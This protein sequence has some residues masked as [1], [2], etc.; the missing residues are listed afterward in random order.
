MKIPA[1]SDFVAALSRGSEAF[2]TLSDFSVATNADGDI[3]VSRTSL[4]AEAQIEIRGDKYLL[5]LPV[6]PES[7][8]EVMPALD[9]VRRLRGRG[10]LLDYRLLPDEFAYIDSVGHLCSCDLILLGMPDGERLDEAVTCV[11]TQQLLLALDALRSEFVRCGVRHRNLKPSNLVYCPDGRL[12]AVRCHYLA[13]ESDVAAIE[14]E[15]AEVEEFIRSH[16][17]IGDGCGRVA[18][19]DASN[20]FDEIVPLHDMMQLVRSGELFGYLDADGSVVFEPQFTY[21]ESFFENRAVVE[22]G[23]GHMGVI[24]R[25]GRSIVRQE[26][27]MVRMTAD[28]HF[29]VLRDGLAGEYDY[30][31]VEVIPLGAGVKFLDDF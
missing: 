13:E 21:A 31:G 22:N 27:D 7:I 20:G 24:D 28:G 6:R 15:F 16:P 29:R 14:S 8:D 25:C 5:C 10:F 17:E 1:I 2:R 19:D 30:M 4:F 3:L 9:I 18:N 12:C 23:K 26:F 11:G